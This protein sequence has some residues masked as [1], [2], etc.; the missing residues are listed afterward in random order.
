MD[1]RSN[2][3]FSEVSASQPIV[4]PSAC[5]D[6][7]LPSGPTC[8]GCDAAFC[9]AHLYLCADCGSPFCATCLADHLAEAHWSDCDTTAELI[10]SH[11]P[12][13][14][15]PSPDHSP[16]RHF[17]QIGRHTPQAPPSAGHPPASC[18]PDA[19]VPPTLVTASISALLQRL[20][21]HLQDQ[22]HA[23]DRSLSALHACVYIQIFCVRW[24]MARG[25]L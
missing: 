7:G 8:P 6:C 11:A 9:A 24:Q 4:S 19:S 2:P 21:S 5:S 16:A 13:F 18:L 12:H 17:T 14:S 23:L 25:A 3:S 20:R 22:G 10:R 1:P 15:P